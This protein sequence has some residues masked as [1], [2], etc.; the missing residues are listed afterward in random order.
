MRFAI[1]FADDIKKKLKIARKILY[2]QN[3]HP[4]DDLSEKMEEIGSLLKEKN[5]TNILEKI[6]VP[7]RTILPPYIVL[8]TDLPNT[9]SESNL[10]LILNYLLKYPSYTG[11]QFFPL[12]SPEIEDDQQ[13]LVLP[14]KNMKELANS[15]IINYDPDVQDHR[16]IITENEKISGKQNNLSLVCIYLLRYF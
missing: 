9:L 6:F 2:L 14:V 10:S 5:V 11:N 3:V 13:F 4:T 1:I 16:E 15:Q 12:Q 7:S 8:E